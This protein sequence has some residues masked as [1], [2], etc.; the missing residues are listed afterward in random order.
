MNRQ[1]QSRSRCSTGLMEDIL[2][3]IR[4]AESWE[5]LRSI[6]RDFTDEIGF[7]YFALI[8]HEDLRQPRLGIVD[9][10]DYTDGAVRRIIEQRGYLRDPVMRGA[11]FA[12]CAFLWSNLHHLIKLD[13]R[14]RVA[15][16]L[17]R[18]EGLDEGIT[19]P[20]AKLGHTLGS[21]T[22]AGLKHPRCALAILGAA[23]IFG[24]FAFQRARRLAGA[25]ALP[26]APPRLEPRHRDCVVLAGR[27]MR[28]KV[29][30]HQL[31]V[32]ARTVESYMRD[33][34]RLFGA[35]DRTELLSAALLAGEIGLSEL[36]PRQGP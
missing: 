35:R 24:V 27:G 3:T 23:Q 36:H 13:Q 32:T 26:A 25:A 31:G 7:R 5:Q 15:L 20:C 1:C 2:R 14:D 33:A 8:S 30:A 6:T 12:D 4:E 22:F 28:D 10:R 29:I 18:R 17:G 21:C 11:L 19:V 34:R 16:E 9:M